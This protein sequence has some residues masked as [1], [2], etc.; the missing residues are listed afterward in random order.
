M[1]KRKTTGNTESAND[2]LAKIRH[3][4]ERFEFDEALR[5][6][7]EAKQSIEDVARDVDSIVPLLVAEAKIHLSMAEDEQMQSAVRAAL[8]KIPM[9]STPSLQAE[10]YIAV[11]SILHA[12]NDY[13]EAERCLG[14]GIVMARDEALEELEIEGALESAR[15]NHKYWQL[16]SALFLIDRALEFCGE[17]GVVN[18]FDLLVEKS[19]I[20][21]SRGDLSDALQILREVERRIRADGEDERLF[22]ILLQKCDLYRIAGDHDTSYRLYKDTLK[23]STWHEGLRSP[24]AVEII[25]RFLL[26]DRNYDQAS[27]WY[28]VH[29]DLA[30]KQRYFLIVPKY[31]LGLAQCWT[32]LQ[33]YNKA[34]EYVWQADDLIRGKY[35]ARWDVTVS[36]L[37]T[38]EQILPQIRYSEYAQS[39]R[40]ILN[41]LETPSDPVAGLRRQEKDRVE[42][43]R[44]IAEVVKTVRTNKVGMFTR[45]GVRVDLNTCEVFHDK[46][47]PYSVLSPIQMIIFTHLVEK[48]PNPISNK[49]I[50]ELY[51][52]HNAEYT[53]VPRRGH[54]FIS[55]L[56]KKL[57]S[58]T[59][60]LT[61]RGSGYYIPD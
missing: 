54:Y 60:I 43:N 18:D 25:G 6:I 38:L 61:K 7:K 13:K 24:E 36:M 53:D 34:L 52:L 48:S 26:A 57:G 33:N 32:G 29:E 35:L 11:A 14:K 16:N 59:I 9:C 5:L 42:L 56:R 27:F 4:V 8:D 12:C 41:Q 49:Q 21:K 3:S 39:I 2:Q 40:S 30:R 23:L 19:H 37:R 15:L 50:V 47:S 20:L 1:V 45:K 55:E 44:Q 58:R 31:L 51:D 46:E 22:L 10:C 28:S 17:K